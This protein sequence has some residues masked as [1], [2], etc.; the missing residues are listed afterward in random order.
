MSKKYH[1]EYTHHNRDIVR[2][3]YFGHTNAITPNIVGYYNHKDELV[4]E[5][6]TNYSHDIGITVVQKKEGSWERCPQLSTFYPYDE[7]IVISKLISDVVSKW[8]SA[9]KE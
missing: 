7:D 4:I 8:E 6:S 3:V 9:K 2:E 5:V 1:I